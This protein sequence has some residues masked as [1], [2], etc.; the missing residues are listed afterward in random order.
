MRERRG[1]IIFPLL[2]VFILLLLLYFGGSRR[3]SDI[4]IN[5]TPVDTQFTVRDVSGSGS[6]IVVNETPGAS[7]FVYSTESDSLSLACAGE[8]PPVKEATPFTLSLPNGNWVC[9]AYGGGEPPP[10]SF[11]HGAY[12]LGSD[13]T[14]PIV[15]TC[16]TNKGFVTDSCRV[17]PSGKSLVG[18]D[19]IAKSAGN[20]DGVTYNFNACTE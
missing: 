1:V 9:D 6:G 15:L 20:W 16:C 18:Q 2:I 10:A 3:S 4:S 13:G 11:P 19:A 12:F 17:I 5:G 14:N 8:V 7:G